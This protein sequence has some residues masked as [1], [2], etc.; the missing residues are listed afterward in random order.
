MS[1]QICAS[2]RI[3]FSG[4]DV[5]LHLLIPGVRIEL[6]VPRTKFPQLLLRQLNRVFNVLYQSSHLSDSCFI[7]P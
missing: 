7:F 6:F 3:K 5:F 1:F 2:Q 4:Y